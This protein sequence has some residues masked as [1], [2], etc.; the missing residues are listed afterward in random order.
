MDFQFSSDLQ[1]LAIFA[2]VLLVPKAF[3][4][5]KIP[6]GITALFLGILAAYFYESI[7]KD[8]L[9]S[10]FAQL[11]ITSLFV[12][13]GLE[14]NFK[15][16]KKDKVY[17]TKYLIQSALLLVLCAGVISYVFK[18]QFQESMIFALGVLTPSAGFILNSLHSYN[19]TQV[20]EYWVRSKAIGKE[21]IAIIML[22]IALQSD[23]LQNLAT[24]IA[25]FGLLLL[26]LPLL[27]KMFF[28]YVCPYAPNSEVPF[29]VIL[30]LIAGVLS[31]KI[32]AYYL[33]GAF[34]VGLVGSIHKERFKVSEETLLNSLTGFFGVFLPFYFFRAGTQLSIHEVSLKSFVI[35]LMM[36]TVLVPARIL[37]TK[38]S[39]R[40]MA[41]LS[42]D[43]DS[44]ISLALMPTLIFG[45]V[46]ANILKQRGIVPVYLVYAIL[47]YTLMTS[48]LPTFIF[49]AEKSLEKYRE[50]KKSR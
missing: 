4:G 41:P 1:Y 15:E 50:R 32:G 22:F 3:M 30:S 37:I 29:L 5:F 23:S 24:S 40:F 26:F 35:G 42:R 47:F 46:I 13:A 45:L 10:I 49:N 34:A 27:F 33:V 43:R 7:S 6:S 16:L 8:Q 14:V 31:K 28:R 39:I 19:I 18:I 25:Y 48:L 38:L 17:L 12:F 2:V 44:N 11:G 20:E 36:F 9:V 21:L